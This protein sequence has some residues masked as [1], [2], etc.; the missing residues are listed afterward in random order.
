MDAYSPL[1]YATEIED[2][3]NVRPYPQAEYDADMIGQECSLCFGHG[4]ILGFGNAA[5]TCPKC[6][7]GDK[8]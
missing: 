4:W 6:H 1:Y 5:V 7:V 8:E 3:A 2:A